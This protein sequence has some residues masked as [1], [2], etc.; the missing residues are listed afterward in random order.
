VDEDYIPPA[1]EKLA[2][3]AEIERLQRELAGQTRSAQNGWRNA[4]TFRVRAQAAEA[5]VAR[6]E[7][8]RQASVERMATTQCVW[9]LAYLQDDLRAA[10]ADAPAEQPDDALIEAIAEALREVPAERRAIARAM[11]EHLGLVEETTTTGPM[12]IR[13]LVSRWVEVK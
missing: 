7:V 12:L 13:R 10:L 8:A 4:D 2:K 1:V 11:V 3:D 5:K 9:N 6:V